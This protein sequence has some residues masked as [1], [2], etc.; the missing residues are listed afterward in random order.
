MMRITAEISMYP[1]DPEYGTAIIRFIRDLRG[2]P[3][4]E[5]VSNALSTQVRG[6]FKTVTG[7]VNRC[8]Q[9][10]MRGDQ[11]TVF[12]VKYLNLDLEIGQIPQIGD[13]D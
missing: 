11:A 4:L 3:G 2:E 12:V 10:A 1:L 6:D 7:A 9:T 13:N 8:M 5:V